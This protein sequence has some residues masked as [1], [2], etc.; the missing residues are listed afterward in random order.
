[1]KT[2]TKRLSDAKGWKPLIE[3][4]SVIPSARF[5]G[6]KN[7][8]KL[9]LEEYQGRAQSDYQGKNVLN[10]LSYQDGVV[11]GSNPFA[12]VLMN[13]VLEQEGMSVARLSD[14]GTILRTDA[15]DLIGKYEDA[16]LVLRSTGDPNTY[17]AKDLQKQLKAR[18]KVQS[19]IMVNLADLELV[20]DQESPHGL[21]FK[22][23][24]DA[25]LIYSVKLD[26]RNNGKRFSDTD[27][28]GLPIFDTNG[29]RTFYTRDSGLSR[30][31]LN[32]GLDLYSGWDDLDGSNSSGRVVAVRSATAGD[33]L[34]HEIELMYNTEFEELNSKKQKALKAAR[35][36]M[37]GDK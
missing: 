4:P 26:N 21:S 28:N 23:K 34:E 37:L 16:A 10:V 3:I 5:L 8:G 19:P 31:D 6:G 24:E 14:F 29:S 33:N 27:E 12:V 20:N 15:L 13:N 17:F 22:L 35:D 11:K 7:F 18:D 2:K 30:L 32:G 36:I 9:A 25:E 1:M